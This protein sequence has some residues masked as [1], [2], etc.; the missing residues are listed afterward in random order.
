MRNAGLGRQHDWTEYPFEVSL[1]RVLDDEVRAEI[2][3]WLRQNVPGRTVFERPN[4]ANDYHHTVCFREEKY[5]AM[6]K[7]RWC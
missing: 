1:G 7:L 4:G 6:F 5:A 2:V 3:S